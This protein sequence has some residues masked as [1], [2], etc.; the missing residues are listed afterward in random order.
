MDEQSS[1]C[2]LDGSGRVSAPRG[3]AISLR[4]STSATSATS[5]GEDLAQQ[6][7]GAEGPT[8]LHVHVH[9]HAHAHAHTHTHAAHAHAHAH[10]YI[11]YMY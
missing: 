9:V 6:Y 4:R 11:C 10:I 8:E 1:P 3:C 7:E 2:V 5:D